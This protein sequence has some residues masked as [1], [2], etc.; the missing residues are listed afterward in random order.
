MLGTKLEKLNFI[1]KKKQKNNHNFSNSQAKSWEH[2]NFHRKQIEKNHEAN[3]LINHILKDAIVK[4]KTIKKIT[5][6]IK[7]T[8]VSMS[9]LLPEL[10]RK[11]CDLNYENGINPNKKN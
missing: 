10:A 8:W 4:K 6:K 1:L 5:K 3:F 7:S 2:D 9:N 11:T